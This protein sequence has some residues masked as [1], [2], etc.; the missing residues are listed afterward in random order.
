MTERKP[1]G[2]HN[3]KSRGSSVGWGHQIQR[4]TYTVKLKYPESQIPIALVSFNSPLKNRPATTRTFKVHQRISKRGCCAT[5]SIAMTKF[6]GPQS[7]L[8]KNTIALWGHPGTARI[9]YPMASWCVAQC[10]CHWMSLLTAIK[11]LDPALMTL[12]QKH[13]CV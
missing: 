5:W 7:S 3:L 10:P 4:V 9:N 13:H 6:L 2:S 12:N 8:G 1:I 11:T